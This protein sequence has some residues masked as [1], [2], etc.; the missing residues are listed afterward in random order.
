MAAL[1]PERT[2]PATALL[3]LPCKPVP[4]FTCNQQHM[5][6]LSVDFHLS[7]GEQPAKRGDV[8]GNSVEKRQRM[9]GCSDCRAPPP[10]VLAPAV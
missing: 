7:G 4:S 5:K 1:D 8:G 2:T 9:A 6:H 10:R 3:F